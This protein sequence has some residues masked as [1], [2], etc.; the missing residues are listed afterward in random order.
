MKML[1]D[2]NLS[3]QWVAYLKA[4]GIDA[5]HWSAVGSASAPD[6]EI[7]RYAREHGYVVFTH[8]LDFGA[9]LAA[10][11][12]EGPSVIQMRMQ[13]VMPSSVGLLLIN[14]LRANESLWDA[15][16]LAIVDSAKARLRVL[17]LR[18]A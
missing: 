3:P 12:A 7:M 14:V 8:D 17:P 2:M 4:F 18:R 5:A 15:G 11:N 16:V 13:D 9:I 6:R 10:S 1:V